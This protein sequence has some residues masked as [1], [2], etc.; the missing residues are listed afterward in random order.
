MENW[1]V[2]LWQMHVYDRAERY[3]NITN[4]QFYA[5]KWE[6]K[7]RRV[8]TSMAQRAFWKFLLNGED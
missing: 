4:N 1:K 5:Q 6:V 8:E 3:L 2:S 7:R